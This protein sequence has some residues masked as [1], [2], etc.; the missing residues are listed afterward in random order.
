[1]D[2]IDALIF[3]DTNILLDFYRIR[4]DVGGLSLLD[5][6]DE[7]HDRIITSNQVEMEYKKN[8]QRVILESLVRLKAPDWSGL[9]PPAFLSD[10]QP[11]KIMTRNKKEM[12]HQQMKLKRRITAILR[13]PSG[14]DPVYQ[15]LQRLFKQDGSYNLT[16]KKAIRYQIRRFAR[17]RF[18]LGYPPRKDKD[19]SIGDA[20]N[21]EWTIY[22][23]QKSRK[24]II[25]VSRDNDYGV[26]YENETI[27]NDWLRQEFKA[28]ISKKRDIILVDRLT[29]AFKMTSIPVTKKETDEEEELVKFSLEEFMSRTRSE[30]QHIPDLAESLMRVI[31]R[32]RSEDEK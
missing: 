29:Q 16:R 11:A 13:N 3:I 21:W 9:A 17:K 10:A 19:T 6:I 32:G 23:A 26:T 15:V 4:G 5:R 24:N 2:T 1:M 25:I 31:L 14:Y 8:R 18:T 20:I 22:C 12:M 28:R 30:T 27:L 7:N